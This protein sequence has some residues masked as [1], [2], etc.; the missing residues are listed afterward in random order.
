[1]PRYVI[2]LVGEDRSG[3]V[4][5]V[6]DAVS[7]HGGNWEGSQL[8]ERAGVFAGVIEISVPEESAAPL[9]S[10]LRELDE[11]LTVTTLSGAESSTASSPVSSLV[12]S[13]VANDRPGIVREVS[14][15]LAAHE[16]SI[17]DLST[18]VRDAAMAGG[19]V[20]EASVLAHAAPGTDLS[21]VKDDLEKLAAE[22]Q[23]EI[24]IG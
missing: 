19:R 9:L 16:L 21:R 20:F 13:L 7:A 23:V 14:A 22:L 5:A 10:A 3:L 4:S 24:A 6:A 12:I 1:M 8:A 11:T 2:T 17:D 18:D 15:V